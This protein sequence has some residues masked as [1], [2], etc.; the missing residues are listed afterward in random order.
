MT[1]HSI[2]LFSSKEWSKA[3]QEKNWLL[4]SLFEPDEKGKRAKFPIRK[5]NP[6]WPTSIHNAASMT[7][8]EAEDH[9]AYYK[10]KPYLLDRVNA[11]RKQRALGN[12]L[13]INDVGIGYCARDGSAMIMVDL[14]DVLD[15]K[16]DPIPEW[17]LELYAFDGYAEVSSGG[18]GIRMLMPRAEGDKE[19]IVSNVEIGG[20]GVFASG[21][22]GALLT[23]NVW[24]GNDTIKRDEVFLTE[25]LSR[26][27]AARGA[28]MKERANGGA[29]GGAMDEFMHWGAWDVERFLAC[30]EKT[31]NPEELDFNEWYGMILAAKEHFSL[32]PQ[33]DLDA[34]AEGVC[35]WSLK[36]ANS[37]NDSDDAKFWDLW[38]RPIKDNAV[39]RRTMGSWGW[40]MDASEEPEVVEK[41]KSAVVLDDEEV[42]RWAVAD[43]LFYDRKRRRFVATE[44]MLNIWKDEELLDHKGKALKARNE[45][46]GAILERLE[47]FDGVIFAPQRG[48]VVRDEELVGGK[49]EARPGTQW[50]NSWERPWVP[51]G[52]GNADRWVEH[53]QRCYPDDWEVIVD[54]CAWQIQ[55]PGEKI[56][57]VVV[58]V[59]PQ[60]SGKDTIL[61]P[62]IRSLRHAARDNVPFRSLAS[63]FNEWPLEK[64][65]V[66]F[67]EA[68][69]MRKIEMADIEEKLKTIIAAPPYTM[70]INPKGRTE[71][72]I[73]NVVNAAIT[74][75]NLDGLHISVNDRR[76]F[77]S[78]TDEVPGDEAYFRG[79]WKWLDDEGGVEEV[80]SYLAHKKIGIQLGRAPES[81]GR[82]MVQEEGLPGFLD[83]VRMQVGDHPWVLST[84][85]DIELDDEYARLPPR[86]KG[87]QLKQCMLF[88]G[89]KEVRN[90]EEDRGRWYKDR[91][92]FK[93]WSKGPTPSRETIYQRFISIRDK[94]H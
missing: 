68:H 14:D 15:E 44:Q 32:Q 92:A 43:G 50:V 66:V 45:R 47:G 51:D 26:R 81:T 73:M 57:W 84:E 88:L 55:H 8:K 60:G 64:T 9:H 30:L 28:K 75:N 86:S 19:R 13:K 40:L 25:A 38:H 20:V 12:G 48:E 33:V 39:G 41:K 52:V 89:F 5:S 4:F 82:R 7:F 71:H 42:A 91:S 93:V 79:L 23:F 22:K 1:D 69:K 74:T 87:H 67:Q 65:F 27:E 18:R 10:R 3:T 80:I 78:V 56:G 85:I 11:E 37:E 34:L 70:R 6:A 36:W 16:G 90:P 76:Y 2:S 62:V 94:H 61:Y 83:V 63:D 35:A 54:F 77:V 24:D 59:G 31:K 29:E 49:W 72:D 58:L 21:G 46:H 53:I 17:A